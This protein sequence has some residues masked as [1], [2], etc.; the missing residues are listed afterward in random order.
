M[1]LLQKI[2]WEIADREG[3]DPSNLEPLLNEVID[4]DALETLI[5]GAE[6]RHYSP[7]LYVGFVHFGYTVTIDGT[8]TVSI[9]DNPGT[10]EQLLRQTPDNPSND[11]AHRERAMKDIADVIAAR[12]RPFVER[13]DGLLE[14]VRK[15]LGM[16]SGT[17]SYVDSDSYV[18]EAV[19]GTV[20][21][22]LQAG[23]I[24]PLAETVCK[25]VVETEQVLVLRNV[26]QEAPELADSAC[27]V[28][29]YIGVPV[30]VNRAI[31]GTFCFYD[32]DPRDEAFSDWER[33]VV[34]LLGNWVSSELERRRQ[35]RALHAA[36]ME[37]PRGMN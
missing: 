33:A 35:E 25:R 12:D 7:Y 23:E 5:T 37:R 27:E 36:T 4:I 10:T 6:N 19:D 1:S 28:S 26:E 34:E 13:L 14:V 30:F 9:S 15:T 31:Y 16:E 18:F 17:L 3:V 22:E 2:V 20:C 24:V 32:T 29:S 21:V 8:G 11:L